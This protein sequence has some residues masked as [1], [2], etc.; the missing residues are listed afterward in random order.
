[1]SDETLPQEVDITLSDEGV[2][3]AKPRKKPAPHGELT[4]AD[5][6]F[7]ARV[8]AVSATNPK[9]EL[10]DD[11]ALD[12]LV[13]HGA[14]IKAT[15]S[16]DATAFVARKVAIEKQTKA[17]KEARVLLP[18]EPWL[19]WHPLKAGPNAGAPGGV[20]G[21]ASKQRWGDHPRCLPLEGRLGGRVF[22]ACPY[23]NVRL[24]EL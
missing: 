4:R 14:T 16:A 7:I 13:Q 5:K 12:G 24:V 22:M 21:R 19:M 1:M 15:R 6:A 23:H 11:L 20:A 17:R 18:R 10:P 9:P 8:D 3:G 2:T